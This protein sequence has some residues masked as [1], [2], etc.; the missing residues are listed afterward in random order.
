MEFPSA[1][2]YLSK[3]SPNIPIGTLIET[4]TV[5]KIPFLRAP[6]FT[7]K[8]TLHSNLYLCTF[9]SSQLYTASEKK[10]I[11]NKMVPKNANLL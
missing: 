8:T 11:L 7:H 3:L 2:C 4:S 9:Y 6:S 10:Q 1:S 5:Y